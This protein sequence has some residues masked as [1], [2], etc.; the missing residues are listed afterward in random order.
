MA[1]MFTEMQMCLLLTT[2][3]K[4]VGTREILLGLVE[5]IHIVITCVDVLLVRQNFY[6]LE[7]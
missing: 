7:Y 3:L 6:R 2:A 1:H 4:K 5:N